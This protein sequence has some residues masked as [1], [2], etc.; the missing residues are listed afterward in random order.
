MCICDLVTRWSFRLLEATG[1]A[2]QAYP[3]QHEIVGALPWTA[4]GEIQ[5]KRD[6]S[7]ARGAKEYANGEE[8]SEAARG[9]IPV[10]P[11]WGRAQGR[12]RTWLCSSVCPPDYRSERGRA[13]HSLFVF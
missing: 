8:A 2:K 3:E 4:A 11:W 7:A 13:R 10:R 12:L 5:K 6:E 1:F 9:A